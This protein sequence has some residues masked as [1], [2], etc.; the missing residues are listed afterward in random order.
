MYRL[1]P[2]VIGGVVCA[3][4]QGSAQDPL[5]R[6]S[7]ALTVSLFDDKIRTRF[8]AM[9][10][11]EMML[12]GDVLATLR[13]EGATLVDPAEIVVGDPERHGGL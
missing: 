3:A 4:I 1:H 9:A 5:D 8:S 7:D 12:M 10:D 11:A 6:V 2:V 13:K